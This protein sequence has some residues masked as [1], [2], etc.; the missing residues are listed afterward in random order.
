MNRSSSSRNVQLQVDG[1]VSGQIAIGDNILQI[2][3][4]HGGV[5]N[6]IAPSQKPNFSPQARPVHIRP[7]AFSGL[8]DRAKEL[9]D[10]AGALDVPES[11]SIHGR[12]GLGKTAFLRY[13]AYNSPEDHFPDGV[14][15]LSARGTNVDDLLQN[16]FE[17]FYT[18]DQPAKPTHTQLCQLLQNVHA[19]ILLDDVV[20]TRDQISELINSA[21]QCVFIFASLERCLWGE[22]RCIELEGLP[23][24]EALTLIERELG[25]RLAAQEKSIAE[26]FCQK[27]KG[28]PLLVI[29]A[30]ALVRQ[31]RTF[32]EIENQFYGSEALVVET[33][34]NRLTDLQQRVLSL[35]AA[36]GNFPVSS[37]HL[38]A[39]TLSKDLDVQLKA[40]LDLHLIQANSPAYN[41]TG[42]LALSLERITDLAKS[43]DRVLEYFIQWIKQNP[44]LP[45]V[46][47]VL[48]LL[49]SLLEKANRDGRWDDV[50]SL[51]RGVEKAL[52]LQKRWQTWL[53]V[54]EWILKAARALGDRATQGWALHQLGTRSLCL[55]DLESARQFLTQALSIRQALG[56][57]AG[58]AVTQHNLNLIT[59]PPV[60]PRE[61]PRSQPRPAP[62]SGGSSALKMILGIIIVVI[63]GVLIWILIH[64][65]PPP[66]PPTP[67][68]FP[69]ERRFEP[70]PPT[71]RRWEPPPPTPFDPQGPDNNQP[72]MPPQ[73]YGPGENFEES[74]GQGPALDPSWSIG[75]FDESTEEEM[76]VKIKFV[77]NIC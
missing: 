16:I 8:L 66:P 49:L 6:I 5:V 26:S 36:L 24:Q 68:P 59:A 56:D 2:G 47:D 31:G 34:L 7:R 65:V 74:E 15:Y 39:L 76:P 54:L 73:S 67:P 10:V 57:R 28:H 69:T 43:E 45:D 17:S 75:M 52:I 42:S 48:N 71:P 51:G 32:A 29:Q 35:L 61:T 9:G 38:A 21:P 41:L 40:L 20:L 46:T 44:P 72:I 53:Q 11:V 13:L 22:G 60:P 62:P 58:A 4:L 63:V 23:T 18:S 33:K 27:S 70:P 50:I 64:P 12:D 3:E 30:A 19:L 55:G 1:N 37:D 77:C 14:L 25:R